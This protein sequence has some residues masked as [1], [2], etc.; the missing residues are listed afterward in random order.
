MN[1]TGFRVAVAGG[2]AYQV[3]AQD[4]HALDTVRALLNAAG[5][6]AV[7]LHGGATGAD[8]GAA[9]WAAARGIPCVSFHV[10]DALWRAAGPAAGPIRNRMMLRNA[11]M[12]V[13]FPGGAGTASA[14]KEARRRRL[15]IVHLPMELSCT[16]LEDTA[17][18]ELAPDEIAAAEA[19]QKGEE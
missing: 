8:T 19:A 13:T 4:E 11:D 17:L 15:F 6:W 16:K 10:E 5:G 18:E 14:V 9:T 3:T 1:A 7:L 12:L 2:R